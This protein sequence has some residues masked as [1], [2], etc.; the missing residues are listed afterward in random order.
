MIQTAI[1]HRIR[2]K[3]QRIR[4]LRA[5]CLTA[6]LGSVTQAAERL[7]LT[8][9]AVSLQVRE[10]EHECVAVLFE[11]SPAGV[12]LTPAGEQLYALAE[13][14]V[15]GVE[16]IFNDFRLALDKSVEFPSPI[17]LAATVAGAAFVLPP[18][19]RR[20]HDRYP[21][22]SVH[23]RTMLHHEE[24]RSL[25]DD[26]VDLALG[27]KDSY[28]DDELVY[29]ELLAYRLVLIA[30]LDHP[31][32]GRASVSPDEAQSYSAVVPPDSLYSRELGRTVTRLC[33]ADVNAVIEVGGLGV[34]KRYVEAGFGIAV[35]PSLCLSETDRLSV[36]D[37]EAEAPTLSYGLYLPRERHLTPAAWRFSRL[38]IP[39]APPR[40]WLRH[41]PLV[42]FAELTMRC[43]ERPEQHPAN[44]PDAAVILPKQLVRC[45]SGNE[46]RPASRHL[47]QALSQPGT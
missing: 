47:V 38:L 8:Q 1:R 46:P 18:Y 31:L 45:G 12:S 44:L 30:P 26:E 22:Y 21:E 7:G 41:R 4:Q 13:P 10:L 23:V 32:A 3:R 35:V 5:F 11:R 24:I 40:G 6:Q 36:I 39:D 15:R 9:P 34:L 33:G 43:G 19:I 25:I 2:D 37:I 28:P 16:E 20:F 17:R 27:V 14:L 29:H 42:T